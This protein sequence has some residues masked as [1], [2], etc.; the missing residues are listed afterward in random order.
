MLDALKNAERKI[1]GTKQLLR[2][3]AEGTV[4]T[5]FVAEDADE[6]IYRRITAACAKADVRVVRVPTMAELGTACGIEIGTAAAAILR[7]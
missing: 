4:E 1:G 5:A 3:L 6:F 2:A 7:G